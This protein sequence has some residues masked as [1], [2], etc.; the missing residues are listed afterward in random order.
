MAIM[1]DLTLLQR[2]DLTGTTAL[3]RI[4]LNIDPREVKYSPRISGIVPTIR[5]LRSRGARV[6][7]I[8]HRG[9]P[10]GAA[11]AKLSLKPF[12]SV[13]SRQLGES[14]AFVGEASGSAR[15]RAI[16]RSKAKILLLENVRFFKGEEEG[17]RKVAQSLAALGDI[18][19]NDAFAVSHRAN[20]SVY[21]IARL[22]PSYAGLLLAGESAHLSDIMHT[23]RKPLVVVIGG[24]KISTK[25]GLFKAFSK[26]THVFLVGGAMA[27]TFLKARGEDIGGSLYEPDAL[28][29]ARRLMRSGKIIL[30]V[31]GVRAGSKIMDIGP[32]T[33]KLFLAQ[34][35][36]AKSVLWNGPLGYTEDP[37]FARGTAALLR[38]VGRSG[39]FS[40]I[41]GGETA[42]LVVRLNL[43]KKFDFVSTGG[44]AML[45]FLSGKKLPG[46]EVLKG[47]RSR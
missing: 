41:G 44:G 18:Y 3:V 11:D 46:I 36:A 20:A 12:V 21:A 30:P 32:K 38:A 10:H 22:V 7:L 23:S 37:R 25:I 1:R 39:A 4:D 8:S 24:A 43:T 16:R 33:Q 26:K 19:V 17:D 13:L 35:S 29:L 47:T 40:V 45:E 27:N 9:R 2:K 15:E 14:V 28:A 5:F 34:L 42:E 31:D 6:L